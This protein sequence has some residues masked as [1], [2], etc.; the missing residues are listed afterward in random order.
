MPRSV[1]LTAVVGA[2][3]CIAAVA[4]AQ[5]NERPA[6]KNKDSIKAE[7]RGI[8]RFEEGRGYFISVK[9]AEKPERENRVWLWISEDKVTVR[10][11]ASLRGKKVLA[12]GDLE[13]LPEAVHANVPPNGMYLGKFEI[14]GVE[15]K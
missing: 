15:A 12:E 7:V 9:S 10:Q 6:D 2:L 5:E 14:K 4:W 13:Q 3:A 11:L 1:F 8:L